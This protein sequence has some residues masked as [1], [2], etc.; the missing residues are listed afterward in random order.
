MRPSDCFRS[1]WIR[2]SKRSNT[3]SKHEAIFSQY[4]NLGILQE[5]AGLFPQAKSSLQ[6]AHE[7]DPTAVDPVMALRRAYERQNQWTDA[8][9]QYET[10]ISMA[11]KS[12]TPRIALASLWNNQ[13]QPDLAQKVLEQAKV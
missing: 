13:G 9:R 10:A 6:R 8:Q 4:T 1:R 2:G 7:L 11:P 3:R 12:V 5:R